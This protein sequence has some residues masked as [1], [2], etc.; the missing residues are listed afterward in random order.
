MMPRQKRSCA[1]HSGL[2]FVQN[3]SVP[4]WRQIASASFKYPRGGIF[5]I[6]ASDCIGSTTNAEN[7]IEFDCF[8]SAAESPSGTTAASA[9]SGPN[10]SRQNASLI[11]D[12]ALSV[13]P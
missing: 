1:K 11:N 5:I 6:P 4:V 8:S 3:K 12:S 13:N 2:H 7:R 9:S 10:P